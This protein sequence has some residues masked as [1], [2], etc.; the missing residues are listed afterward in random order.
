MLNPEQEYAKICK[1]KKV[2]ERAEIK[3]ML[4]SNISFNPFEEMLN[5]SQNQLEIL[6]PLVKVQNLDLRN[7]K[8]NDTILQ[9]INKN[10][11]M[12]IL[13]KFKINGTNILDYQLLLQLVNKM[14]HL[15]HLSFL[16]FPA[17]RPKQNIEVEQQNLKT[18]VQVLAMTTL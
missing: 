18:L 6:L 15:D 14:N 8:I 7:H 11:N 1:E 17:H 9:N 2:P 4:T 5:I 10:V 13:K 16:D 3:T 12:S